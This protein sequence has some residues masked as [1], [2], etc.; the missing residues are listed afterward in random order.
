MLSFDWKIIDDRFYY[1]ETNSGKIVGFVH[2]HALTSIWNSVI[3][4][5]NERHIAGDYV[6]Q[7]NQFIESLP[8]IDKKDAITV[9]ELMIAHYIDQYDETE[10]ADALWE[11]LTNKWKE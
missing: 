3:Y 6:D 2:K 5:G 1:Y 11:D 4:V 7:I 10:I 9:Y 8:D